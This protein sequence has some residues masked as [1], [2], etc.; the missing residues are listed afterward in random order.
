MSKFFRALGVALRTMWTG[1]TP[2]T[3]FAPHELRSISKCIVYVY[4][5]A[6]REGSMLS[7]GVIIDGTEYPVI[8]NGGYMPFELTAGPHTIDLKLS[9]RWTKG[10]AVTFEAGASGPT[11]LQVRVE[12][13]TH[14]QERWFEMGVTPADAAVAAEAIRKC[15]LQDPEVG[16]RYKKSYIMVDN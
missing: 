7:P 10:A 12:L 16:T 11:Y 8:P 5:P 4:R 3:K 15:R 6:N 1:C 14:I 2:G 13:R 9:D